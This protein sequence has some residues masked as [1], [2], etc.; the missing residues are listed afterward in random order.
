MK[1]TK[2]RDVKTISRCYTGIINWNL[3]LEFLNLWFKDQSQL[4]TDVSRLG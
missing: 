1:K 4:H 2:P 3:D